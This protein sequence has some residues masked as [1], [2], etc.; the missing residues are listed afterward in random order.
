MWATKIQE[1]KFKYVQSLY[2]VF[3]TVNSVCNNNQKLFGFTNAPQPHKKKQTNVPEINNNYENE[4]D[5][6]K[7]QLLEQLLHDQ[8]QPQ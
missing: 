3:A 1:L 5:S 7:I 8:I 2:E 6:L 4:K